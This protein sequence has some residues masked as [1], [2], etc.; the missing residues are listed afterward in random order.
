MRVTAGL[1]RRLVRL[2]TRR[3]TTHLVADRQLD[4]QSLAGGF[5]FESAFAGGDS[6]RVH[7]LTADTFGSVRK[8]LSGV[9]CHVEVISQKDQ[10]EAKLEYVQR[11]GLENCV[12]MGNGRNDRL[13]LKN[14]ALGVAVVQAEG[15]AVDA[16]LAADIVVADILDALDLLRHP[17][18]LTATLRS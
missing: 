4:R 3:S 6:F 7:V 8:A 9:G 1:S 14:A 11:L 15:S 2:S 5:D 13:M 10:A 18:R 12:C 16:V 17:L